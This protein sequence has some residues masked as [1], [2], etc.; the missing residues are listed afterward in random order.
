MAASLYFFLCIP[1]TMAFTLASVPVLT[2]VIDLFMPHFA[3]ISG[4]LRLNSSLK[5][6]T[7]FP[8]TPPL[9]GQGVLS[10]GQEGE[11]E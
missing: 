4:S 10:W 2:L 3:M 1:F 5:H 8:P 9:E 11:F 7:L 6:I